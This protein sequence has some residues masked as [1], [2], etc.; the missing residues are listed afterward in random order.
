M[1]QYHLERHE[2]TN[3]P[4]ADGFGDTSISGFIRM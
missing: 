3:S 2:K 1:N 4:H